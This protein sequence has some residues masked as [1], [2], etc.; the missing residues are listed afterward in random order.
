MSL[1]ERAALAVGIALTASFLVLPY[2][3]MSIISLKKSVMNPVSL[4]LAPWTFENY[5]SVL[6]SAYFY[7]TIV[8]SIVEAC[9]T[10]L[11]VLAISIPA[12]YVIARENF[13][14]KTLILFATI[15]AMFF[16]VVTIT[17]PLYFL[18][19]ALGIY[20]TWNGLIFPYVGLFTPWSIWVLSGYFKTLPKEVE[21]AAL[22]DGASRSRI[23]TRIVIPMSISAIVTAALIVFIFSWSEFVLGWNLSIS[24]ESRPISVGVGTFQGIYET[25]IGQVTTAGIVASFFP[26]IMAAFA[27]KFIIKGLTAGAVKE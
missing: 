24:N 8:N 7:P 13:R 12:S 27:Q 20:N 26:I 2:I 6:S 16:P 17:G 5:F 18:D 1:R 3:W 23:L 11:I 22:V 9:S 19:T 21:E 25:N 14:G 4:L 15:V 10:T